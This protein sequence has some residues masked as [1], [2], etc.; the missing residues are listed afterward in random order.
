MVKELLL[1]PEYKYVWVC[2][3]TSVLFSWRPPRAHPDL[4]SWVSRSRQEAG[5]DPTGVR[6]AT[7]E[8]AW[9][10]SQRLGFGWV[11]SGRIWGSRDSFCTGCRQEKGSSVT[12]CPT[13]CYSEGRPGWGKSESWWEAAVAEW[14]FCVTRLHLTDIL[15]SD[16]HRG[17]QAGPSQT[18]PWDLAVNVRSTL[19]ILKDGFIF[20]TSMYDI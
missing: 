20:D 4:A 18:R 7:Q 16:T 3:H 8:E 6:G 2:V 1:E 19:T 13:K 12:Q 17:T 9:R 11:I 14:A 15:W 5:L 10:L